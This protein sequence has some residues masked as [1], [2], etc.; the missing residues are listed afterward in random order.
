M[1]FKKQKAGFELDHD[2]GKEERFTK[3]GLL[4]NRKR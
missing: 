1:R 4:W 2:E 3:G